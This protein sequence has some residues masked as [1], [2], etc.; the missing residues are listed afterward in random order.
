M[1][2]DREVLARRSLE[3]TGMCESIHCRVVTI[4][5]ARITHIEYDC[6]VQGGTQ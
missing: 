5:D 2:F 3:R 4:V 1:L 6:L